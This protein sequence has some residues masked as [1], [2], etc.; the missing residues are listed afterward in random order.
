MMWGVNEADI[1]RFGRLWGLAGKGVGEMYSVSNIG[2]KFGILTQLVPEGVC[3]YCNTRPCVNDILG[4]WQKHP[5]RVILSIASMV[6]VCYRFRA[7]AEMALEVNTLG[8][9]QFWP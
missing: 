6:L 3:G 1:D 7:L 5:L 9:W 8:N 4:T 2:V